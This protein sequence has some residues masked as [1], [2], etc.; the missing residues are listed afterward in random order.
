MS[1]TLGIKA[2]GVLTRVLTPFLPLYLKWRMTKGK[3]NPARLSERYGKASVPRPNGNII[4]MHGASVGETTML[5]PLIDRILKDPNNHVLLTSGTVTSAELMAKRLPDRAIHQFVPVDTSKAVTKFL[6]HW[7]PDLALWAE[8]EIWPNLIRLTK[9]RGVPLALVN[10]RM[11]ARHQ[12][13]P[14]C[15]WQFRQNPRRH[16]TNV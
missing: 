11:K 9:R 4:W 6:G 5:L 2:Y 16:R 14:L 7:Q 13:R 12:Q 8:S 1:D 3:E 10:A 15:L